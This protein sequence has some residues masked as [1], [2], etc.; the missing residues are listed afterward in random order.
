MYKYIRLLQFARVRGREVKK[1]RFVYYCLAVE[2]FQVF[3]STKNIWRLVLDVHVQSTDYLEPIIFRNIY[4]NSSLAMHIYW[5]ECLCSNQRVYLVSAE[6]TLTNLKSIH[7]YQRRSIWVRVLLNPDQSKC[8][9]ACATS[10][11]SASSLR[12]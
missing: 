12:H 6:A 10:N 2:S 11:Q 3:C 8:R 5:Y 1:V 9:W 4:E 7:V